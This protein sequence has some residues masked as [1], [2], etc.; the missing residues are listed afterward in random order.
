MAV[1]MAKSS[2]N[3]RRWPSW[4]RVWMWSISADACFVVSR[5]MLGLGWLFG[6]SLVGSVIDPR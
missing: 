3:A 2:G 4:N 1:A 6:P 5:D